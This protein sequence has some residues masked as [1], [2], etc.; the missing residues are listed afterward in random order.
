MSSYRIIAEEMFST[1]TEYALR[2]L[3]LLAMRHGS[4]QT[5]QQIAVT[6]KV[7]L[8]YLLKVLNSLGRAGLVNAQRGKHGGFSLAND[9]ADTSILEIVQAVD[10]IKR[11]TKC[12]LGL[13]AHGVRLCSLH[14]KLDDAMSHVEQAFATTTLADLIDDTET[15]RPLCADRVI[16]ADQLKPARARKPAHA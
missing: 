14:R 7:P 10:P 3:V 6:T 4:P 11:I 12:P 15:S 1:T 2:A 8:D 13:K 5:A 16:S 9:P